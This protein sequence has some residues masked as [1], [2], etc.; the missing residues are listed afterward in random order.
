MVGEFALTDRQIGLLDHVEIMG[1]RRKFDVAG[2]GGFEQPFNLFLVDAAAVVADA[3]EE[4]LMLVAVGDQ[5]VDPIEKLRLLLPARH[6]AI[7]LPDAQR[8][9]LRAIVAAPA[10]EVRHLFFLRHRAHED[11]AVKPGGVEDLRQSGV[12]PE[13]VDAVPDADVA[14]EL[15]PEITLAELGLAEEHFARRDDRVGL[16]DPA[17][18]QFPA[19]VID[20]RPDFGEQ[21]RIASF[22]PFVAGARRTAEFEERI[23]FH[24]PDH[25]AAG[26]QPRRAPLAQP[27]EPDRVHVGIADDVKFLRTHRNH[28][29]VYTHFG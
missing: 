22:D 6:G 20:Q 2:L 5:P 18:H 25:R 8:G 3:E 19:A 28:P 12:L 4:G 16:L 7:G 27:P 14:P 10:E 26:V 29:P 21:R 15:L 23:F 13:G 24:D 17:A 11:V 9:D 1:E